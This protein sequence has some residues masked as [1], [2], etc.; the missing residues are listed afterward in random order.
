VLFAITD[1]EAIAPLRLATPIEALSINR[2]VTTD[3]N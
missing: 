1:F 2:V 3:P